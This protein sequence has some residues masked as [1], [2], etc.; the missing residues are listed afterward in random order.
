MNNEIILRDVRIE[1]AADLAAIYAYYVENTWVTFETEP[2]DVSEFADRIR[3]FSAAYPYF[4]AENAATGEIVGYTYAHAF[5]ERTAYRYTAETTV[6]V[7][8]GL[9][10]GG[11]G[12]LLYDALFPA[13]KAMGLKNAMAL[14]GIPN[15]PSERFHRSYGFTDAGRLIGVGYKF[16][17]WLDVLYMQKIL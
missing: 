15:E 13:M 10:Q 9:Q 4:V 7:K 3:R 17:R 2:P 5:H 16:D 12:R 1:D 14:L 11:I 6:Y 8:Q